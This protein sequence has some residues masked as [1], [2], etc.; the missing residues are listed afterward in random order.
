MIVSDHGLSVILWMF[1][2]FAGSLLL[3]NALIDI[4]WSRFRAW[5]TTRLDALSK[6][7]SREPGRVQGRAIL[8]RPR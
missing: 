8:S 6:I 7:A 1:L 3:I 2:A 4:G 5:C